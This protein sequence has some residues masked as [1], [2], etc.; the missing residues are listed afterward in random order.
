MFIDGSSREIDGKLVTAYAIVK[1]RELHER[2]K[3]PS[4]WSGQTAEFYASVRARK[5]CPRKVVIYLQI[6]RIHMEWYMCT[7]RGVT[8]CRGKTLAHEG[9]MTHLLE[10]VNLP[11]EVAIIHV[12]GHQAGHSEEAIAN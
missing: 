12:R 9:L 11:E 4:T 7:E 5:L 6:Q 3:L 8:N 2:G 10:A 1:G